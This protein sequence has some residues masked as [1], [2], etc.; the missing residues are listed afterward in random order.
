[1]KSCEPQPVG[2]PERKFRRVS[3]A[4]DTN[5][6]ASRDSHAY[7]RSMRNPNYEPGLFSTSTPGGPWDTSFFADAFFN[8]NQLKV[9]SGTPEEF[10]DLLGTYEPPPRNEGITEKHTRRCEILSCLEEL[11]KDDEDRLAR[12]LKGADWLLVSIQDGEILEVM[13]H[14]TWE[15]EDLDS[16][17]EGIESDTDG[18]QRPVASLVDM[19]STPVRSMTASKTPKTSK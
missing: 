11:Y 8:C 1:M 12:D 19:S 18:G 9:F 17:N 5:F 16:F 10:E 15:V 6:D 3:F 4:A 13:L 7:L 2:Q 14:D